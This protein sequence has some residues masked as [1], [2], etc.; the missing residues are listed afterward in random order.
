MSNPFEI[1]GKK[2]KKTFV[3]ASVATLF[4]GLGQTSQAHDLELAVAVATA[5]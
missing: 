5:A 2:K 3:I 4:P 1:T